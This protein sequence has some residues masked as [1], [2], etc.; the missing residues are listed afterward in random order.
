MANLSIHMINH[1]FNTLY[2]FSDSFP[3]LNQS[4]YVIIEFYCGFENAIYSLQKSYW[5]LFPSF[6]VLVTHQT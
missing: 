2:S 4:A 3:S 6:K 5:A 1:Y